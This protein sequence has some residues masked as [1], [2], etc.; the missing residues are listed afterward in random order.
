M[1]K[2]I[3]IVAFSLFA[4]GQ[5]FAAGATGTMSLAT[6]GKALYGDKTTATVNTTLIGKTST[7]VGL[8]VSSGPVGY[9]MLSQHKSGTREFGTAYNSTSV[10]YVDIAAAN[11]GTPF[12]TV[13][14][15]SDASVFA[16]GWTSM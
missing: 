7:G 6:T 5:A 9:A 3:I 12:L 1:K 15:A 14:G 13:P 16:T 4:A 8:G 10:F 11:I 2:I